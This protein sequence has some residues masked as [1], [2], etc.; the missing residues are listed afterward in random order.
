VEP[1]AGG[2][3]P[4]GVASAKDAPVAEVR[5][6]GTRGHEEVFKAEEDED[7]PLPVVRRRALTRFGGL[8][9]LL[10]LL[11]DL[12][13]PREVSGD[14]TLR[15]RTLRWSLHRL[16]LTLLPEAETDD[17][18]ALAFA[19]LAP[20]AAP[21]SEGEEG[22]SEAESGALASY[23]VRVESALRERLDE[24]W[25][26]PRASLLAFVCRRRAEVVADPGWFEVRLSLDDVDMEIRR[27]G[28]DLDPGY[29]RWLGVVVK[30]VY[31]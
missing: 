16:A 19:G 5:G 25:D 29:L 26:E 1:P 12:G 21:P 4:A 18:A 6:E 28:L 8:L 27:S 11:E 7:R 22:P 3:E 31:E 9:F 20:D 15:G 2:R 30:F 13:L 17:P 10:N 24:R 23:A 14:E